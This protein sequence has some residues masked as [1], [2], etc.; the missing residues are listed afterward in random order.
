MKTTDSNRPIWNASFSAAHGG[1]ATGVR[2]TLLLSA[3][4]LLLTVLPT[5]FAAQVHGKLSPELPLGARVDRNAPFAFSPDGRHLLYTIEDSIYDTLHLVNLTTRETRQIAYAS[6]GKFTPDGQTILFYGAEDI[7]SGNQVGLYRVPRTGGGVTRV[8]DGG[9]VFDITPD[10][11]TVVYRDQADNS[12]RAVPLFG[13][14]EVTLGEHL[15][16][17]D[18]RAGLPYIDRPQSFA[19]SP[20]GTELFFAAYLTQ[21]SGPADYPPAEL[22]AVPL[23]G[24]PA[25]SLTPG[26]DLYQW[27]LFSNKT[28]QERGYRYFEITEDGQHI[29]FYADHEVEGQIEL[30]SVPTGGGPFVKLNPPLSDP[31]FS[32]QS[33][34]LSRD[35]QHLLINTDQPDRLQDL[36]I[37]PV[38]GGEPTLVSKTGYGL[39]SF[40]SQDVL[41]YDWEA[42]IFYSMPLSGSAPTKLFD[43]PLENTPDGFRLSPDGQYLLFYTLPLNFNAGGTYN[44][45]SLSLTETGAEPIQLNPPLPERTEFC[46]FNYLISPDSSRVV[47]IADQEVVGKYE[48]YSVPIAGGTATRLNLLFGDQQDVGSVED[49]DTLSSSAEFGTTN[50][51]HFTP[52]GQ[53][54]IYIADQEVDDR[55]E[56]FITYENPLIT[57]TPL[58]VAVPDL[59]YRLEVTAEDIDGNGGDELTFMMVNMPGWLVLDDLGDGQALLYGTPSA[60]DAGQHEVTFEVSN[61][62]GQSTTQTFTLTVIEKVAQVYLPIMINAE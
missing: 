42:E 12:L 55:F 32:V 25:V 17:E 30:Y 1:R 3:S 48:L 15:V 49:V 22:F 16:W 57:S 14:A 10:G 8:A 20:D 62:R 36:H 47:Y 53:R 24:G 4:V 29:L 45:F 50:S 23:T 5:L 58:E 13:G 54:V 26:A 46:C 19:I 41:Y 33:A 21:P 2:L 38:A 59:P 40:D 7:T 18:R 44:Y 56:L 9:A 11:Q 43:W 60:V 31:D 27:R 28:A 34:T 37:V 61:G 52:N 51:F 35:N 6:A 39:F